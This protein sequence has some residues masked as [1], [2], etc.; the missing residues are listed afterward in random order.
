MQMYVFQLFLSADSSLG[1]V[2]YTLMSD[3]TLT[4]MLIE[5]FDDETKKKYQDKNEMYLDV[6]EW[7]CVKCDGNQRVTEIDII[8]DGLSGS[9]ELRYVPPKVSVVNI[10]SW[11]RSRMTGSVD[12]ACLPDGMWQ[13]N[14]RNNQLTGEIKLTQLPDNM[15]Y[16]HLENNQLTGE[17]NLTQLPDNMEYLHLE[18]NQLTGEIN[19][20]KLPYS[21]RELYLNKNQLTGEINVTQLPFAMFSLNLSTNQ[22]TGEID[23]THLPD[24]INSLY[25]HNNQ[26]SG[27]LVIK[28]LPFRDSVINA[29]GNQFN[30]I[31]VIHAETDATIVLRG[32]GVTS[33]VDEKGR[34]QDM[35]RF[36]G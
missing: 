5:G 22:L 2:D 10:R 28:G 21:M 25:L 8:I 23:L 30:A 33:V 20:T 4:E 13:L 9:L 18:N 31:A 15:E 1:R 19:L 32:S 16:L 24:G 26:L 35:Q 7:S 29:L 34:E 14:L 12:L 6:C 27:S 17:I 36:L 11:S 3:Q